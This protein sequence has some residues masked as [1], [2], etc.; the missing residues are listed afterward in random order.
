[1]TPG[2]FVAGTDTGVGKTFAACALLLRAR[3]DGF[4]AMAIKPVAAGVAEDGENEDVRAHRAAASPEVDLPLRVRN[5]YCF[6]PPIAPHLAAREAGVEIAFSRIQEALNVARKAADRVLVEGVGGFRVPLGAEGDS[7]D[8]ARLLNL[9]V[10]LVVGMRLGCINHALLTAEAIAARRLPFAGWIANCIDPDMPR[11]AENLATLKA[12]LPAPL[13]GVLSYQ[14]RAD[15][16]R[17]A[18]QAR[19]P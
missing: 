2:Y 13:L 12:T 5:P 3:R 18:K 11:F 9:P 10:I 15:P 16:A 17:A 4:R 14:A 1:M 8:L 19:W 7:A 6:A